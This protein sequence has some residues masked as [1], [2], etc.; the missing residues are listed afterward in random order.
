MQGQ[1]RAKAKCTRSL[2][3]ARSKARC[4][5]GWVSF[6]AF[7]GEKFHPPTTPQ[8]AMKTGEV[9][10]NSF[11]PEVPRGHCTAQARLLHLLP[12]TKQGCG[13]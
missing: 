11:K 10:T 7:Q 12:I 4:I 5:V 9:P 3:R 2:D 13:D 6:P 1:V 8:R